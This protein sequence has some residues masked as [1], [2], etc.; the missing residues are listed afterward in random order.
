M[1]ESGTNSRAAV[2]EGDL[3]EKEA[4]LKMDAI[5]RMKRMKGLDEDLDAISK[6]LKAAV[7]AGELTEKEAWAKWKA[8]KK[9][10]KKEK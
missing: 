6:K 1:S 7:K 5:K 4:A 2:A 10:S 9:K 3:S 8:L